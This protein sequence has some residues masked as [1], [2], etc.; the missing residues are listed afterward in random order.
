M[1][2]AAGCGR[3]FLDGGYVDPK[4]FIK[5]PNGLTMLATVLD[6]LVNLQYID[7]ALVIGLEEHQEYFESFKTRY[8]PILKIKYLSGVTQGT[9]DTVMLGLRSAK[10]S[11][12]FI[13]AN[14]DQ[15]IDPASVENFYRSLNWCRNFDHED[16]YAENYSAATAVVDVSHSKVDNLDVYS[17]VMVDEID[18]KLNIMDVMI[19]KEKSH[20][21]EWANVGL[22]YFHSLFEFKLAY[23]QMVE[24]K[25]L[26]NGETY[27]SN[28]LNHMKSL[29]VN[30]GQMDDTFYPLGTPAAFK[31]N[32]NIVL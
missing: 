7:E 1:I 23:Q 11:K 16:K 15:Y 10:E 5:L 21:S 32:Q 31:Q 26:H 19:N 6:N 22:F 13:V 30:V 20:I 28:I 2:P 14:C 18:P 25:D 8:R 12:P 29:A 17:Y 27:L 9:A 4:P 24:K 3:R